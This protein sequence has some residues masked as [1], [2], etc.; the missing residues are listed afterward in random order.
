MVCTTAGNVCMA[1]QHMCKNGQ[2]VPAEAKCNGTAECLDF[3]D[4][5][6]CPCRRD[7]FTCRDGTCINI[8]SRCNGKTDC[9]SGEDESNCGKCAGHIDTQMITICH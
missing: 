2:C 6:K 4:E 9:P 7:E 5:L 3:S 8:A 1:N